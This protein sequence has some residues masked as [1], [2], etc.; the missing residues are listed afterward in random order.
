MHKVCCS[1]L[2]GPPLLGSLLM[3]A[4]CAVAWRNVIPCPQND[5]LETA[6]DVTCRCMPLKISN[7]RCEG[8]LCR[9]SLWALHELLGIR[10]RSGRDEWAVRGELGSFP[11]LLPKRSLAHRRTQ[12]VVRRCGCKCT[13]FHDFL[14]PN[15]E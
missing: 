4:V 13:S 9:L 15:S 14:V 10:R 12:R 7:L 11:P 1:S 5:P 2:M 6:C 8:S 3:C